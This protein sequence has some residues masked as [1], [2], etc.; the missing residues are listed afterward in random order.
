MITKKHLLSTM[1]MTVPGVAMADTICVEQVRTIAPLHLRA[2]YA[3]DAK[4]PQGKTFNIQDLLKENSALAQR[5]NTGTLVMK[6]GDAIAPT[7]TTAAAALTTLYFTLQTD[8]YR[9]VSLQIKQ[10]KN[11]KLYVNNREHN[12]TALQLEPGRADIALLCLTQKENKD[13]LKIAVVGDSLATLQINPQGARP[14][15][16]REMIEGDHVYNVSLSPS[17]KYLLAYY[18]ETD[19]YGK[20]TYRTVLTETESGR[21]LL[22]RAEYVSFSWMPQRD[23]LYLTRNTQHGRTLVTIDPATMQETVMAHHLPNGNFR[24]APTEDY[25][26][27]TRTEEGTKS[28]NGL[29]RLE[30]PDDRMPG[31]RNRSYI[32]RHDLKTGITQPLTFG[33]TSLHLNDISKDGRYLLLSETEMKTERTPFQRTGF[34]RMDAYT[35]AVDTLLF[36]EEYVSEARF[37]PNGK[38][39]LV[40]ASPGAFK[41]IG[42]EIKAGQIANAFDYRLY[43][44]TIESKNIE[45]LLPN[46]APSVGGYQWKESD[47]MIYFRA[48]EGYGESLFRLNPN[49][50]EVV[51]YELPVSYVQGYTIANAKKQPRAVFFGQTGE[52][53]REMFSCTLGNSAKVK[54]Q[55]IGDTNFDKMYADVAIGTCH[56][57]NFRSSLGDSI[58]GFYF[59][60][61][62]FD[63]TKQYPLIV[64]YY[65]GCTPTSKL[66]EFHYPLAVLAAQGYV[67]YV[68]EPSGAI[69]YGQ[70][71]AARHVGTWGEGSADDIIEGT[72]AF[73]AEHPYIN[74][75]KVGCMGAS[76]GGFMTQYLQTRTDIFAAAISHAGISNIASYWGGGYWG[77][78]YGE[79]AQ[80]GSF[81][82]NNPDM[83]VKQSPLFNAHKIN[84]PL[85]LLHGTVDTNVPTNESQQLFTA[86]RIL[87][88]PVSYIQIDGQDHVITDF[89]KRMEWQRAIF[90]WFAHWLK[91]QPLWWN[92][93]YPNDQFGK[94]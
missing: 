64:Y 85:L 88:R 80:Q 50:K 25:L 63:E 14:Y 75:K 73:I 8:C 59:L 23:V 30:E 29:K 2:P 15:T 56:D 71:F 72:K 62:H 46:F 37:S 3:T 87:G 28:T 58:H 93:L 33:N 69:G 92:E 7:D 5:A 55:R 54:T 22:C 68:C 6:H 16:M 53:A 81:P 43:L 34:L 48:T 42:S 21:E 86:L 52:R 84:T 90:A 76:Y 13:S 40:K 11:Y 91:D 45:P 79:I 70:E 12:G 19:A 47:G 41:G 60:P 83:Y 65:G 66:L 67:V 38:Q 61:P 35:G 44:Y 94:D 89:A 82:W 27:F 9:K 74:A 57:W 18:N 36:D 51:R 26:I 1:L 31:W 32:V 77:Y 10:L 4:N 24:I 49:T 78:T 17:G 20:N 39:L